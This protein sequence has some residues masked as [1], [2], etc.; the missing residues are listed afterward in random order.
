MLYRLRVEF[1][2]VKRS[3]DS[4]IP[5]AT[6]GPGERRR[7]QE[8]KEPIEGA[9]EAGKAARALAEKLNKTLT[10]HRGSKVIVVPYRA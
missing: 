9:T 7:E 10:L 8:P 5:D 1:T 4:E 6:K 2:P 3:R